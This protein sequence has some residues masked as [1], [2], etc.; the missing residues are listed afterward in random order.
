MGKIDRLVGRSHECDFPPEVLSLPACSAAR[1]NVA[2]SSGDIHRQVQARVEEASPVFSLDLPLMTRLRPD[3]ILTQS[4]CD[5]CAV[6]M[7]LL[8]EAFAQAKTR[9]PGVLSLDALSLPDVWLTVRQVADALGVKEQ[10][11]NLV[12]Q[13]K[14]RM[15]DIIEKTCMLK[16]RP[17]VA[18]IEWM[19]PLMA[20]GNWI[21]DLVEVAGGLNLFGESGKHSPW[22]NWEAVVEHDPEVV[23]VAPC[24][25]NLLQTQVGLDILLAR[26]GWSRLRAVR[27]GRV[28][29]V[30]G[31]QY[32]NRP[33][34]RLVE[35]A[36]ILAEIIH[37][38]L[39]NFE[40][41][42]KGWVRVG[43]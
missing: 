13:L 15:V 43:R 3:L 32:F 24:G 38:K 11:T 36:E 9:C 26:P 2:V 1:I 40:H 5:V 30:D 37:P 7:T 17:S 12:R 20:A 8:K 21:P 27:T 34:P 33:G 23:V 35:T 10:G 16:R 41:E 28:F 25:F 29:L 6:D 19:D 42:G 14:G 4:Q 39:F 31:Q 22:M 18:C